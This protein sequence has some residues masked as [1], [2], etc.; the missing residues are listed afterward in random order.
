M[1]IHVVCIVMATQ[2]QLKHYYNGYEYVST[3]TATVYTIKLS[4]LRA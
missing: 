4:H 2:V 3:V 1:Y